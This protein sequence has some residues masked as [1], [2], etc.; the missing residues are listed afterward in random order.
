M[1]MAHFPRFL[2]L[3]LILALGGACA[4]Q[5]GPYTQTGPYTTTG[6]SASV[7]SG[8]SGLG[9]S[10]T[11]S[12]N[13]PTWETAIAA[14]VAAAVVADETM[15]ASALRLPAGKYTFTAGVTSRPWIHAFASGNV[16]LNFPG[17]SSGTLLQIHNQDGPS[18]AASTVSAGNGT[19]LDGTQGSLLIAGAGK[20]TSTVGVK[21]G[22]DSY[23]SGGRYA[24]RDVRLTGLRIQDVG[25]GIQ[26]APY[27][28][29]LA[30]V[31]DTVVS[32]AGTCFATTGSSATNAG[33]RM[34]ITGSTCGSSDVGLSV[35]N[36]TAFTLNDSSI[37]FA[38]GEAAI[39]FG[40]NARYNVHYLNNLHLE[41]ATSAYIKSNCAYSSY[42]KSVT[43][44]T[45]GTNGK[46]RFAATAHGYTAG[47]VVLHSDFTE[48]AYNVFARVTA[49]DTDWYE[50]NLD[51]VA[52]DTG[53][54]NALD[55][56]HN[57]T[58]VARNLHIVTGNPY[59]PSWPNAPAQALFQGNMTLDLD[60]LFVGG[61]GNDSA[62][63]AGMFMMD[64]TVNVTQA[65]NIQFTGWRQM[66][67]SR[68]H[69]NSDPYFTQATNGTN[70]VTD[71]PS[72]W[73]VPTGG[74]S[75]MTIAADNSVVWSAGGSAMAFA[76]TRTGASNYGVLRGD[77]FAVKPGQRL[78]ANAA[79][80]GGTSTGGQVSIGFV[81]WSSSNADL[82]ILKSS[83]GGNTL[84]QLYE[85][86]TDPAYTGDRLW[87]AKLTALPYI[88]V[89]PGYDQA[90]IELTV[91]SVD[92]GVVRISYV[93]ANG[94]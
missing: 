28:T 15:G 46:A 71:P 12:N 42:T 38:T 3:S 16:W 27:N 4:A 90:S 88:T 32:R 69:L 39:L 74:T 25:T 29:Y 85:D 76:F 81:F 62:S 49:V 1:R 92:S 77:R 47:K 82:P 13:A 59:A 14:K 83:T 9:L 55:E 65:R 37:D 44:V 26:F 51:Y 41:G 57:P 68:L 2:S 34:T 22:P 70:P 66:L 7:G 43:G 72:T 56:V 6:A 5:A 64:D 33:E 93:G 94:L 17:V 86:A 23:T 11:A 60:G 50:T 84:A 52:D 20:A 19:A 45:S 40:A 78:I 35:D 24:N 67:S 10:T 8:E 31:R 79:I 30:E 61:Y 73:S 87:W 21:L 80:Y 58:V 91:A 89:P 54:S 75:N 36:D 63:A 18:G 53:T 48:T